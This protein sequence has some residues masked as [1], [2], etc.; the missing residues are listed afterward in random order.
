MPRSVAWA[1]C[2]ACENVLY[3]LAG[4]KAGPERGMGWK[5]YAIALLVFNTVGAFFVY[6]LQ[7][8]QG[9]LPFNPQGLGKPSAPIPRSI[10]Q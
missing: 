1:G 10:R 4:V 7:R 2:N 3:R 9:V 5:H 6:G 8:L